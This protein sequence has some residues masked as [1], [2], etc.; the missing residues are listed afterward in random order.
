M[1][2]ITWYHNRN[3]VLNEHRIWVEYNKELGITRLH[4]NQT[5]ES[6]QGE[7]SLVATNSVGSASKQLHI[8][9]DL[10]R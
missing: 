9:L 6:D 2:N 4:L 1:P 10:P 8:I 7:W 5:N 3:P